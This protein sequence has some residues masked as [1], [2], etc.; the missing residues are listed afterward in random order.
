MKA[1]NL[2]HSFIHCICVKNPFDFTGITLSGKA[3]RF[4]RRPQMEERGGGRIF[5][6]YQT[7]SAFALPLIYLPEIITTSIS[8]STPF[9]FALSLSRLSRLMLAAMGCKDTPARGSG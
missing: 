1:V 7:D 9:M 5:D 4:Q 8:M 3:G 2:F 6:S